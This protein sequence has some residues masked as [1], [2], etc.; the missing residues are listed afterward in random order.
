MKSTRPLVT[1]A[2]GAE[3]REPW[4]RGIGGSEAVLSL[5]LLPRELV[6]SGVEVAV[7]DLGVTDGT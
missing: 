5:V 7:A 4:G 2:G 6:A 3:A 1:A